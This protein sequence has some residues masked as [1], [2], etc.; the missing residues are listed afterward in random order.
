MKTRY[1]F[2]LLIAKINKYIMPKHSK[3]RE[4]FLYIANKLKDVETYGATM[5]NKA[6]YFIDNL[7]YL[8]EG[9]PITEFSYIKQDF[10][11][12]PDPYLFLKLKDELKRNDEIK[13]IESPYYNHTQKRCLPT[14][15]ADL[16][17]FS[18]DEIEIIDSVLDLL[19]DKNATQLSFISHSHPSWQFARQNEELPYYSFLLSSLNPTE[20]DISWAKKSIANF[21]SLHNK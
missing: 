13:E 7:Y 3:T 19:K 12:T 16:S 4:L 9:H 18:L 15:N 1:N 14:R 21:E 17:V 2:R 6:F 20:D 10:G 8:K 5:L 11:A